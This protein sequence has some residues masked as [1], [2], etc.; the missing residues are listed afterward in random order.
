MSTN[1][2]H[3]RPINKPLRPLPHRDLCDDDVCIFERVD[4]SGTDLL[5]DLRD[6]SMAGRTWLYVI[7]DSGFVPCQ[8]FRLRLFLIRDVNSFPFLP[9]FSC[10]TYTLCAPVHSL[11]VPQS[12]S[13]IQILFA[14][15]PLCTTIS[16]LCSHPSSSPP[17]FRSRE[18]SL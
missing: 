15:P 14:L 13:Q 2:Y 1:P 11:T 5:G 18:L 7:D 3:G 17:A 6:Q 9:L 4:Q 10:R 8:T 16:L 12:Y